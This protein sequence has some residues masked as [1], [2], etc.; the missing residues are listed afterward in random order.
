MPDKV[1]GIRHRV[2]TDGGAGPHGMVPG[3]QLISVHDS[4]DRAGFAPG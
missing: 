1:T 3:P 4:I 2:S